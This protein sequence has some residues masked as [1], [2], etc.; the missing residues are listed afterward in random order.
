M[1]SKLNY[2]F[3]IKSGKNATDSYRSELEDQVGE[4]GVPYFTNLDN[5]TKGYLAGLKMF[6]QNEE[7]DPI[8]HSTNSPDIP[9]L[10]AQYLI[11]ANGGGRRENL[12]ELR[13]E[14]VAQ[15]TQA[16]VSYYEDTI[17]SDMEYV[18]EEL[19]S[20]CTEDFNYDGWRETRYAS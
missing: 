9:P 20:E 1:K 7:W 10:V 12:E 13:E 6:E 14:L 3:K 18:K 5:E 17:S 16:I 11:E 19:A 15:I 4:Y 8:L 2:N